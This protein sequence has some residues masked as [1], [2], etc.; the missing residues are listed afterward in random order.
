MGSENKVQKYINR[1]LLCLQVS[2]SN[3]YL[4]YCQKKVLV[5]IYLGRTM[6]LWDNKLD[7]LLLYM[8][9]G[10]DDLASVYRMLFLGGDAQQNNKKL[11][12]KRKELTTSG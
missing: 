2:L 10:N 8:F 11:R 6:Q 7:C 5:A 9:L 3:S 4:L 1:A 12:I